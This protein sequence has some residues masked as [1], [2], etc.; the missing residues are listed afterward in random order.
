MR[1][2]KEKKD[3]SGTLSELVLVDQNVNGERIGNYHCRTHILMDPHNKNFV[4]KNN[5]I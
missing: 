2:K 4:A 5:L 3:T 1:R